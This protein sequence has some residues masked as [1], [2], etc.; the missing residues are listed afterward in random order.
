MVRSKKLIDKFEQIKAREDMDKE[1]GSKANEDK[2]PKID[3]PHDK[4]CTKDS[5]PCYT[6]TGKP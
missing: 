1:K 2:I 6:S 3:V 4:N 5:A